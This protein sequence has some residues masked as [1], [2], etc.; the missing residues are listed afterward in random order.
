[1]IVQGGKMIDVEHITPKCYSYIRFSTPD[2][3]KGDSLPR[4]L[5]VTKEYA[6][7]KGLVLDESLNFRDLGLSAYSGEHRTRGA[8]GKFLE[9]VEKGKIPK[10]SIL[11]V[12]SLDRLSREQILSAINQFMQIINQ[13]INIVTLADGMEYSEDSINANMGQLLLSITIMSRAHE[14]SAMK[15]KRL[16]SAWQAKR[17]NLKKR[18]LTSI[19]PAWLKLD[20]KKQVFKPITERSQLIQRVFRLYLDG[21]GAEK[22]ARKLNSE[23]IPS[24]RRKNGWHKS[25]IQK[26]LHNRAVLGEFQPH[27]ML[28]KKRIP[29]GNPIEDYYPRIISDYDFY[30]VQERMK[31][32]TGRGGRNGKISNLFGYVAQCGYCGASMQY[33]NKGKGDAYLVCDNARRGLGC[34]KISFRYDEFENAFLEYCTEL[35]LQDI[36]PEKDDKKTQELAAAKEKVEELNG[37]LMAIET[38]V[39]NLDKALDIADSGATI[40]HIT[41]NYTKALNERE[42]L[43]QS[44]KK[45]ESRLSKLLSHEKTAE[46]QLKSIKE[47]LAL[48]K[49]KTCENLIELRQKLRSEIRQMVKSIYVF[50][51]GLKNNVL[52]LED[53]PNIQYEN[54]SGRILGHLDQVGF[55]PE[56]FPNKEAFEKAYHDATKQVDD[57]IQRNTGKE[58]RRFGILFKAGGFREIIHEDGAYKVSIS[59]DNPY[60]ILENILSVKI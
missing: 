43:T 30:S 17:E 42:T 49:E 26:I 22:I 6:A 59:G 12:E 21:N 33:I 44:Y 8:L 56:I 52:S 45:A 38:K 39:A 32:N 9:L 28:N 34:V 16:R 3:I 35:N 7:K 10:G 58:H 36:L 4:Q 55:D 24:W 29:V 51:E 41:K 19:S 50:P 23:K 54:F 20:K 11:I 57:H 60:I 27:K 37:K 1:L 13:G 40:E 14:E 31:A 15:S 48:L 2:Q 25:Y 18:K 5:E 53:L 46:T 47:L